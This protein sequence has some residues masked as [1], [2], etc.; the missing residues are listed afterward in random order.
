MA[1]EF[2]LKV[3]NPELKRQLE[4]I[5]G[6]VNTLEDANTAV[7]VS[8]APTAPVA[9][10]VDLELATQPTAGDTF[11][12]SQGL[13]VEEFTF[14]ETAEDAFDVALGLD[15]SATQA[16]VVTAI[17]TDSVLVEAGAFESDVSEL[18]ALVAGTVGDTIAVE[19]VLTD[20]TDGFSAAN[21]SGGVDGTVGFDGQL[22]YASDA[23]YVSV[24]ESTTAVSNWKSVALS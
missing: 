17:N 4:E 5:V 24:G 13:V 8:G 6:V 20:E 14:V 18:T 2:N 23:L 1:T 22:R 19:S 11:S 10:T 21:L 9:S 7:A 15:V 16:N 12:I 3:R